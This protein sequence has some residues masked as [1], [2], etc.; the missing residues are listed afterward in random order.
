M[1]KKNQS[2][3]LVPV[4]DQNEM[5]FNIEKFEQ[6]Q[7]VAKIFASSSFV[8]ESFR[9]NIPN[10]F[11]A[12]NMACRL[13]VDPYMVFQNMYVIH[14]RPGLQAQLVIAMI[15]ANGPFE[16]PVQWE[17]EGD[18]KARRCTA[19]GVL[20]TTGN[21]CE[22]TV[23]WKM[24]EDEK[25]DQKA[26]SKWKTMPDQM[27][28]YRSAT[29][30]ARLYC[31]E[32]MMGLQTD[33]E[34]RDTY[35]KPAGPTTVDVVLDKIEETQ[36][37]EP[38]EKIKKEPKTKENKE[39]TKIELLIDDRTDNTNDLRLLLQRAHEIGVTDDARD[40]FLKECGITLGDKSTQREGRLA[41]FAQRIEDLK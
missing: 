19:Y 32:V 41:D 10:C 9:G 23:S 24:V 2:T 12:L 29:F 3:K 6:A 17:F 18:G 11:I 31:P 21:R 5:L 39:S 14:G 8:P 33:D 22:A 37:Q 16:D 26:G 15:N 27:F 30:L 35:D 38:K 40:V 4:K 1:T 36:K 20:R 28:R 34:L 7:R 25:W 13:G